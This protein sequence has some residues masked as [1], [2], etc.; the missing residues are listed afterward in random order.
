MSITEILRGEHRDKVI[1]HCLL[2][3]CLV[4]TLRCFKGPLRL[5]ALIS[6][7]LFPLALK[8]RLANVALGG[9]RCD[10]SRP[11]KVL[12]GRREGEN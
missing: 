8:D 4:P 11:G 2:M 1:R 12:G 3:D 10:E 5:I 7:C 6:H 9:Q